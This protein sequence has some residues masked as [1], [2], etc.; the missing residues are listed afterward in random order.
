MVSPSKAFLTA[1]T[2]ATLVVIV[3]Y[4][5]YIICSKTNGDENPNESN[6]KQIYPKYDY[7]TSKYLNS[8]N[9]FIIELCGAKMNVDE[10]SFLI[11]S[12]GSGKTFVSQTCGK[13]GKAFYLKDSD[14][15]A[16]VSVDENYRVHASDKFAKIRFMPVTFNGKK[17]LAA[18]FDGAE[19]THYLCLDEFGSIVLEK[20]NPR[21]NTK[22]YN[23][24][25][26]IKHL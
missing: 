19:Q 12:N 9:D 16:Y 15:N 26:N 14:N 5:I 2:V 10:N 18:S 6:N 1:L 17:L 8:H 4:V 25:I 22:E 11:N 3:P 21:D 23:C 20:F 7:Q 13:H 24:N